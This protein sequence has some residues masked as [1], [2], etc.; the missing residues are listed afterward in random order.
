[1]SVK[2]R[3]RRDQIASAAAEARQRF[4]ELATVFSC[5][6]RSHPTDV[7]QLGMARAVH[8]GEILGCVVGRILV[9]VVD[10]QLI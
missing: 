9:D 5:P 10:D 1:M 8:R 7:V 6:W 2:V 3:S 4:T